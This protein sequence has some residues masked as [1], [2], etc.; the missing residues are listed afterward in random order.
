MKQTST[1]KWA[2]LSVV[3]LASFITN[4]DST[5]V[6]IGL[7]KLMQGLHLSVDAG[8]W[9]ITAYVITSTVFLLP[10]GKWSDRVGKKRI[11]MGGFSL[12]TIATV[13]CALAGSSTAIIAFRFLQ[14]AGA[15]MA[16]ATAT[17]IIM[18]TFAK[19]ELG[20]A[21]SINATSWVLGAIIG[22]VIGGALIDTL[23]WRSIF[24]LT[25]PFAIAGVLLAAF[26]LRPDRVHTDTKMDWAGLFT[27]GLGLTGLMV[28]LSEGGG[29]GWLSPAV[30]LLA[31]GTVVLFF[32]FIRTEK[33]AASPLFDLGLLLNRQY[34]TGLLIAIGYMIGFYSI[35]FL[36]TIYLQGALRLD[37]LHA[38]LLLIPLSVPQLVLSPLCGKLV[39]RVGAPVLLAVGL[40]GITAGLL[41]LGT[42]GPS[43]STPALSGALILVSV[44]NSFAWPSI[45]KTILETAPAKQAGIA[46]GMF[47]TVN[48]ASRAVSQTFVLLL[49]EIGVPAVLVTR[50]M[51]GTG[52]AESAVQRHALVLSADVS[53]RIFAIFTAASVITTLFFIRTRRKTI[54]HAR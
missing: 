43:L 49:M 23:G 5:I 31:A 33:H 45:A 47:F 54:P 7:P 10:A 25:A 16:L 20:L 34:S 29:W 1:N 13:L 48:Y 38:G 44:S 28:I 8:L 37:A 42:L 21:V 39:D 4:V 3:T 19:K 35:T 53:F 6:I 26:V 22:P 40:T 9:V 30:I 52:G 50:A 24:A 36:L 18:Q 15:S 12:F 46:S 32:L 2:I 41:L 17:P 51:A 11:F 27:F 14:G